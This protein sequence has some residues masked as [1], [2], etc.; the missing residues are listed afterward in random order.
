MP[1]GGRPKAAVRTENSVILRV[2]SGRPDE[3]VEN[4]ERDLAARGRNRSQPSAVAVASIEA[5][6][7]DRGMRILR[8][9]EAMADRA[10]V[11]P[12]LVAPIYFAAGEAEP[13]FDRLERAVSERS[14]ELIFI[15]V[16]RLLDGYRDDP[17]YR[18]LVAEVGFLE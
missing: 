7:R 1:A 3:A 12:A 5:G 17:R 15:Q 9:L 13:G 2:S 18:R 6:Q 4:F 16:N 14:R 11:S 10:Y 8:E